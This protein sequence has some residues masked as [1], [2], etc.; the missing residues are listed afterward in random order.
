MFVHPA[1]QLWLLRA[2][3]RLGPQLAAHGKAVKCWR[4]ELK[5]AQGCEIGTTL[6]GM[7]HRAAYHVKHKT[8]APTRNDFLG[9]RDLLNWLSRRCGYPRIYVTASGTSRKGGNGMA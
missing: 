7:D 9:F 8:S 1:F 6:N 2:R 5:L 4:E 3:P